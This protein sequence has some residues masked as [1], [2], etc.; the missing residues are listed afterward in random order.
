MSDLRCTCMCH[1]YP[2]AYPTLPNRPCCVCGHVDSEG[3][4]IGGTVYGHWQKDSKPVH[5]CDR[6]GH[7]EFR[8]MQLMNKPQQPAVLSC[9]RCGYQYLRGHLE[10][11]PWILRRLGVQEEEGFQF[12]QVIHG[13]RDRTEMP[14]GPFSYPVVIELY[15]M[16]TPYGP[17]HVGL[18]YGTRTIYFWKVMEC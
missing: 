9:R 2:G 13:T 16:S 3:T 14:F 1:Q 12:E 6:C 18:S 8:E 17:F 7:I 4:W 5:F 11:L 15:E 10:A